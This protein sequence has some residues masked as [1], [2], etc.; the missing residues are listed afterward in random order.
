MIQKDLGEL[1]QREGSSWYTGALVSVTKVRISPDLSA[2][3]VYLSIFGTAHKEKIMADIKQHSAEIRKKL[4][5]KA[6][7]QLRV[8]PSLT[9]F[10]DDSVDYAAHI[11]ELL[12]K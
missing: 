7:R 5:L 10:L 6:G 2:A 8:V 1:F 3:R 11:E 12:K 4:G 9:F